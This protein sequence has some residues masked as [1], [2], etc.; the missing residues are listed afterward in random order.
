VD[1]W[2][3]SA[4]KAFSIFERLRFELRGE[5]FNFLNHANF[6]GLDSNT[7]DIASNTFGKVSGTRSPRLIQLSG[8]ITW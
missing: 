8:K 3:V 7:G 1:N 4:V 5:A 2:D 6:T